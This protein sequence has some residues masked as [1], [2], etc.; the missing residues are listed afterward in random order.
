MGTR[1]ELLDT[2]DHN[3]QSQSAK[4][5]AHWNRGAMAESRSLDQFGAMPPLS[6][7]LE[8]GEPTT[9]H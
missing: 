5:D 7:K 1:D 6:L 8:P 4:A 3:W 9:D 2:L